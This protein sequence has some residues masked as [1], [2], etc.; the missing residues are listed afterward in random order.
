MKNEAIL[1]YLVR[2]YNRLAFTH[3]YIFGYVANGMVYGARVMDARDLLPYIACLDRASSKNGGTLQLKYKPNKAQVEIIKESAVEIKAICS[4]AYLEDGAKNSR[5]NRGQLFEMLSA[6]AYGGEQVDRKNA[7]F[8]E[9][10]DIVVKGT[11]YQVKFLKATFTDERTL[12]N[13]G[14]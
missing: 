14:A 9:C 7:K 6:R 3:N 5:Y 12:K 2:G 11:H 8:T 4:E 13:F 1:N 10:G